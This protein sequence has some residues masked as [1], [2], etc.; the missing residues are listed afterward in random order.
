[1]TTHKSLPESC[2]LLRPGRTRQPAKQILH[3]AGRLAPV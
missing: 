1:M 3:L 2:I